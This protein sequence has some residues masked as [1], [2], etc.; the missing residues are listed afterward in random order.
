M[1]GVLLHDVQIDAAT[2][3]ALTPTSEK[4]ESKTVNKPDPHTH[5]E[6]GSQTRTK[7]NQPRIQPKRETLKT[8]TNERKLKK[9]DYSVKPPKSELRSAL[10]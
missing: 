9:G 4:R 10:A 8:N 3:T 5:P 7:H 1:S 2:V 6:H